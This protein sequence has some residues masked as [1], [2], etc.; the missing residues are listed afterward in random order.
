MENQAAILLESGAA[1]DFTSLRSAFGVTEYLLRFGS[2]IGILSQDNSG[3]IIEELRNLNSAIAGLT[4]QTTPTCINLDGIFSKE[5]L[6]NIKGENNTNEEHRLMNIS[7]T[8]SGSNSLGVENHTSFNAAMR[9]SAILEKMRQSGNCR[10]KELQELLPETSERTLRYD[11][12]NLMEQGL[13]ERIGG[14]G[15]ATYYKAKEGAGGQ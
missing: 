11:V 10:L 13:V 6:N 15:P 1:G 14:G 3:A 8:D 4:E 7:T 12:Q 2:D 5:P 9:Q